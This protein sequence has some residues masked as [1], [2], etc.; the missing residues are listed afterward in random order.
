MRKLKKIICVF[1]CIILLLVFLIGIYVLAIYIKDTRAI[2]NDTTLYEGFK[3]IEEK[4]ISAEDGMVFYTLQVET[5]HPKTPYRL[6]VF[7]SKTKDNRLFFVD[8]YMHKFTPKANLIMSSKDES[9]YEIED[10]IIN[11]ENGEYSTI[12]AGYLDNFE[13]T[14]ETFS[15][16]VPVI[17]KLVEKES[18]FWL[19]EGAE[20]LLKSEEKSY[21]MEV[22]TNFQSDNKEKI[23]YSEPYYRSTLT[24][25]KMVNKCNELLQKYGG[26]Q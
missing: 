18:W 15:E 21:I 24:Y 25:E 9:Y 8:S 6:Y 4:Q 26:E 2:K 20:F 5:N 16:Y 13:V 14:E 11:Y 1:L 17:K 19:Y 10:Q 3:I 7:T 12:A 22:L 23:E